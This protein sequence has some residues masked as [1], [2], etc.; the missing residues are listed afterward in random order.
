MQNFWSK[1]IRTNSASFCC[2]IRQVFSCRQKQIRQ[3]FRRKLAEFLPTETC[4]IFRFF[5]YVP[6]VLCFFREIRQVVF[7][8]PRKFCR[9]FAEFGIEFG[10]KIGH[11]NRHL[12]TGIR[13]CI[14]HQIR[15]VYVAARPPGRW[16]SGGCWLGGCGWLAGGLGGWLAGGLGWL[17][18]LAWLAGWRAGS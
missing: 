8:H 4:R 15:Q 2:Q 14:R 1:Q 3:V 13:Q 12:R 7:R 17:G 11:T 6:F 16:P 18:W 5:C 9:K 10:K